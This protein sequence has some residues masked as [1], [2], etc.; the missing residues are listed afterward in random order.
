MADTKQKKTYMVSRESFI[1][2]Y[3]SLRGKNE[4]GILRLIIKKLIRLRK[5]H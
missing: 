5:G 3:P 4:E 1:H 2:I